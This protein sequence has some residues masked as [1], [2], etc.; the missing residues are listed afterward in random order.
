M[1]LVSRV[2]QGDPGHQAAMPHHQVGTHMRLNHFIQTRPDSYPTNG[3][4]A[5]ASASYAVFCSKPCVFSSVESSLGSDF[6]TLIT[7]AS[8]G[9][10][11]P[12]PD[13][14]KIFSIS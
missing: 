11:T 10:W 14:R 12:E 6:L 7:S 9:H 4:E 13:P 1:C 3:T 5:L 2:I 8:A